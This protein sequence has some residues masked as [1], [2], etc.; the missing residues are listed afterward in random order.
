MA[1]VAKRVHLLALLLVVMAQHAALACAFLG[2]RRG[3]LSTPWH[4]LRLGAVSRPSSQDIS[5][6]P[7]KVHLLSC[8]KSC[9]SLLRG[10]KTWCACAVQDDAIRRML[11]SLTAA[12]AQAFAEDPTGRLLPSIDSWQVSCTR[13]ALLRSARSAGSQAGKSALGSASQEL[14]QARPPL[15]LTPD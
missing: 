8:L 6:V 7:L 12:N 2:L 9:W 5:S 4:R 11:G 3:H 10:L 13:L 14:V 1:A 15:A